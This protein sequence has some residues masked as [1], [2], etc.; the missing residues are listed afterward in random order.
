LNPTDLIVYEG[1]NK[2]KEGSKV[3]VKWTRQNFLLKDQFF[4]LS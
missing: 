1:I 3:V 4:V 2:V